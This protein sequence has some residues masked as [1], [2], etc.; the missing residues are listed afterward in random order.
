MKHH[1]T[2]IAILMV[3]VFMACACSANP[4]PTPTSTPEA[5]MTTVAPTAAAT[6]TL[7][8]TETQ[9]PT[10]TAIPTLTPTSES[11]GME[12]LVKKLYEDKIITSTEGEYHH[13]DDFDEEWAQLYYYQWWYTDYSPSNFII[14]ADMEWESASKTANFGDSGCG[15]VYHTEDAGD[16][17]ATFLMMDGKVQTYRA[18]NNNWTTLKGGNAGRFNTPKDKAHMTL[19]VDNQWITVY[20]NEKKV[21]HFQDTKLQ[22]GKLALTLAS[23]TNKDFGT[24]CIMKN[25]ELWE[26]PE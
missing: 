13:L 8:P 6:E 18:V 19:V 15:F 3:W 10:Q 23:G 12:K 16:H 21:V 7:K 2:A 20:V 14:Q 25:V 11:A 22:G 5:I 4:A 9:V 24:R 1:R 17:H 26:L